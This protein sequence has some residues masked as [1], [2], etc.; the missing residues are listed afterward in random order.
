MSDA[1]TPTAIYVF[2]AI[3]VPPAN[4]PPPKPLVFDD[5]FAAGWK[6]WKKASKLPQECINKTPRTQVIYE[7]YRFNNRKQ[8]EGENVSSY[9]TKLR[10][11]ARDC[12][13]GSITSVYTKNC[14][15][16]LTG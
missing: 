10:T 3:Y 16:K 14:Q 7:R 4:I 6:T 8:E 15:I 1:E 12:D 2:P 9:L 13:H 11:I 5:N